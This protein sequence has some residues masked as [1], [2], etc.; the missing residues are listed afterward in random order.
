MYEYHKKVAEESISFMEK[1]GVI[2]EEGIEKFNRFKNKYNNLANR[3]GSFLKDVKED[4]YDIGGEGWEVDGIF[5]E[6]KVKTI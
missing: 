4:G 1:A 5:K 2:N 6:L 3:F